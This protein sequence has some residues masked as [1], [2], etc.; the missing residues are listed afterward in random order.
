MWQTA[1]VPL[2]RSI[3]IGP[4]QGPVSALHRFEDLPTDDGPSHVD[5]EQLSESALR[6]GRKVAFRSKRCRSHRRGRFGNG[7]AGCIAFVRVG[8]GRS[9]VGVAIGRHFHIGHIPAGRET[10]GPLFPCRRRRRRFG[11]G[12]GRIA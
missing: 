1:V 12:R 7:L 5:V 4:K 9:P 6:I 11:A 3:G 2:R 10:V 8:P